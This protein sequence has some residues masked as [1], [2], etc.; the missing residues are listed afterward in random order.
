[1]EIIMNDVSTT[2]KVSRDKIELSGKNPGRKPNRSL[3]KNSSKKI[4]TIIPI[5]PKAKVTMKVLN[6]PRLYKVMVC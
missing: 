6:H 3:V 1:M 4:K 2:I 5:N